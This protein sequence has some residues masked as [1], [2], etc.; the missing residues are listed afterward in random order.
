MQVLVKRNGRGL[1]LLQ[2]LPEADGGEE[3]KV[4]FEHVGK[5]EEGDTFEGALEKTEKGV[6]KQTNQSAARFKLMQQYP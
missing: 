4:L 1:H 3:M 5:V 6:M 2:G